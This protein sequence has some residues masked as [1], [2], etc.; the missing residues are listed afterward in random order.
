MP[1]S[2]LSWF[3]IIFLSKLNSS[4][5]SYN[6]YKWIKINWYFYCKSMWCFCWMYLIMYPNRLLSI[7]SPKS[8]LKHHFLF[9]FD[10]FVHIPKQ[11]VAYFLPT[12]TPTIHICEFHLTLYCGNLKCIVINIILH[13]F[14][15]S[16][17]RKSAIIIFCKTQIWIFCY[18]MTP[19]TNRFSF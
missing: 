1:Q 6:N 11:R 19:H 12:A 17:I 14:C 7:F 8:F 16:W 13:C 10:R 2:D 18:N 3:Y 5:H 15:F 4:E 9:L